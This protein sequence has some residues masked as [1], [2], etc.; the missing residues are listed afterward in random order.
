MEKCPC[1]QFSRLKGA[2]SYQSTAIC[3]WEALE[4]LTTSVL[5]IPKKVSYCSVVQKIMGASSSV[6]KH[7]PS[8]KMELSLP[9]LNLHFENMSDKLRLI[10]DGSLKKEAG[11]V[12]TTVG[13]EKSW[14]VGKSK[15]DP[16]AF[17]QVELSALSSTHLL[18]ITSVVLTYSFMNISNHQLYV[19]S[20]CYRLTTSFSV[21]ATIKRS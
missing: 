8:S 19:T 3:S 14:V 7:V 1:R 18:I 21:M 16:H 9:G 17:D 6:L 13:Y 2:V 12:G 11:V 20:T 10:L 5:A 4:L 15:S